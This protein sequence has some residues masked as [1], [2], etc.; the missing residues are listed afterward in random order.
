[1]SSG[2]YLFMIKNL[3]LIQDVAN[4]KQEQQKSVKGKEYVL[5]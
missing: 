2:V 3:T 4:G 5:Q 1:M